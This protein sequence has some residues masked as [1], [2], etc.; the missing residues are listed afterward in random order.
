MEGPPTVPSVADQPGVRRGF[1]GL[2]PGRR[3]SAP[4]L[5]VE[6][7]LAAVAGLG[8]HLGPAL[9]LPVL[10]P[11]FEH[12]VF[13]PIFSQVDQGG[14]LPHPHLWAFLNC[15]IPF[16]FGFF[17]RG[18]VLLVGPSFWLS[19]PIWTAIDMMAGGGGH[20]LGP[21]EF[22]FYF[23]G[24]LFFILPTGAGRLARRW[25]MRSG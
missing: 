15:A 18:M 5:F 12:A 13:F 20:N 7:A 4:R 10:P 23:I 3:C 16:A 21:I 19:Y 24:S 14:S 22:A 1:L 17:G 25:T 2:F 9:F 8:L 11:N 6:M